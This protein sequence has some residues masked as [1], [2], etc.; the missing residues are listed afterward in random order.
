MGVCDRDCLNCIHP[1]CICDELDA[2]D[3]RMA[4]KI[5]AEITLPKSESEKS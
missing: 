3:Y 1:D 5:E 2:E 4:R